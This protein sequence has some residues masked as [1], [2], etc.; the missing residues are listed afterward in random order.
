MEQSKERESTAYKLSA[1]ENK[2]FSDC[3]YAF[4][5]LCYYKYNK[6]R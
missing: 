2:G 3:I 1:V 5:N 6:Q 4:R